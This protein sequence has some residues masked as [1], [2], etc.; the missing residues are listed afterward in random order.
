MRLPFFFSSRVGCLM[1]RFFLDVHVAGQ[2]F[3][4]I[5]RDFRGHVGITMGWS[6]GNRLC[7][8]I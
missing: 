5:T 7:F 6:C 8:V 2:P 3:R 1:Q 4:G